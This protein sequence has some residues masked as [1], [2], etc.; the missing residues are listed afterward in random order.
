M[1]LAPSNRDTQRHV[2]KS[3][4][5]IKQAGLSLIELMISI[6]LGIILTAGIIEIYIGTKQTYRVQD[7][8]SR[9]QENARYALDIITADI[10]QAGYT[11]CGNLSKITPDVIA[12]NP[13]V[14]FNLSSALTGHQAGTS[15]WSP[16]IPADTITPLARTDVITVTK[17]GECGATLTGNLTP[18]NA[19]IKVT[20]P[21]R[22]G[23]TKDEVVM[24]SNCS[25]ADIFRIGSN[26]ST[27]SGQ[28][29]LAQG[30]GAN[31][32]PKLVN[33]YGDDAEVLKLISQTYYIENGTGGIPSLFVYDNISDTSLELIEGV[34]NIQVRYGVD[35]DNDGVPEKYDHAGNIN[36]AS[37]WDEVVTTRVT[38]LM[39]TINN[40]SANDY[41]F[42]TGDGNNIAYN[43]DGR[44]RL[45]FSSTVQMRN[46]GLPGL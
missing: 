15:T 19:N 25:T 20:N 14:T 18:V 31:T 16:V 40:V 46:R 42:A 3:A 2:F 24:V 7:E 5:A 39:R 32:Q 9:L 11:G 26:P 10:R 34:E 23:F 8:L 36:A 4:I 12:K 37:E 13:P 27:N 43:G 35:S 33:S 28:M 44:L 29:T 45:Q 21:N 17:G 1:N 22:C 41:T 38:L 6:T 30:A